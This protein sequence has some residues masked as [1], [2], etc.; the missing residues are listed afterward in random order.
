MNDESLLKDLEL[1][2]EL[3]DQ[4]VEAVKGGISL[5]YDFPPGSCPACLSG[6]EPLGLKDNYQKVITADPIQGL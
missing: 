3:S 6:I 5:P 1:L 4:E 2:Q